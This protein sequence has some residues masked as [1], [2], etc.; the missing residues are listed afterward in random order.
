MKVIAISGSPHGMHGTTGRMVSSVLEGAQSAGA[1]AEVFS[2]ADF[3][4][5]PCTGCDAC[6]KTGTCVIDDDYALI[7]NALCEADGIVLASPN[8]VSNISAQMKAF[9]DRSQNLLHCQTLKGKYGVA[10]VT[11]GGPYTD[12]GL[13]YLQ[14]VMTMMG[15]W[16]VGSMFVTNPQL[17][18]E[19]EQ[20]EVL[21]SAAGIGIRLANAIRSKETFAEQEAELE[22]KFEIMKTV[23]QFQKENWPFKYAYWKERWGLQD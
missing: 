7:K 5:Q 19:N 17:D 20:R 12:R 3:T 15:I 13:E 9:I 21:Q 14:F 23:V 18:D 1:A 4:V 2:L 10:V 16:T 11:S 22:E 6:G 8:Y